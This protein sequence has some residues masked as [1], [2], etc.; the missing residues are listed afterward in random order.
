M[1]RRDFLF[2][3]VGAGTLSTAVPRQVRGA[4]PRQELP[5]I[6]EY[7]R[8][9]RT[10][11]EA[12]DIG[13][14][15]PMEEGILNA[16]LMQGVNYIDT[17]E[18][19]NNGA[20]ERLVGR[21]IKGFD[22]KEFFITTKFALREGENRERM[23]DRALRCLERLDTEYMDCLMIHAASAREDVKNEAFHQ[24]AE[25]LKQ[26]G[27]LRYVGVSCHGTSWYNEPKDSM[28]DVLG[29][30]AEDGRFDVMLLA[31][32]YLQKN[33]G[34]RVLR[35]CRE[36]NIGTTLMKTDPFGTGAFT[37]F[38]DIYT[39]R[40]KEGQ[41][42]PEW[43]KILR[44]KYARQREEAGPFLEAHNLTTPDQI[45]DAAIRFVLD[46]QDVHSALISFKTYDEVEA[47]LRLSGS[48]LTEA[49]E[50]VLA[51]QAE[52]DGQLYCR[53][54]CAVCEPK[55]PHQVPVN[56]IMRYNHYYV[57]QGR[58]KRALELYGKL[59]GP[60]ADLCEGCDGPCQ[61][62]CPFSIPIHDLLKFAHSNLTLA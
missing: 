37:Y 22:R 41:P 48:R 4:G 38:N 57:A 12:S 59:E 24:V 53:H 47:Y 17:A 34:E 46:N 31:Y 2:G 13:S 18:S 10:G 25:E 40:E 28:E 7:R 39:E 29:T 20:S 61:A 52:T 19:Y 11:F 33:G 43:I 3:V 50:Q 62:A 26:E 1:K 15:S 16:L 36:K 27:K 8:L 55:C 60:K 5:R 21:V 32:N 30:A 49:D 42:A 45:R 6:Q 14:G 56:T 23:K 9:G 51:A 58:E 44:E 35:T 54:A